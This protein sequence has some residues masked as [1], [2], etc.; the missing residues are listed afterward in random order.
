MPFPVR[1]GPSG[2]ATELPD[3]IDAAPGEVIGQPLTG[4]EGPAEPIPG[5]AVG[6][7]IRFQLVQ[8]TVLDPGSYVVEVDWRA[9]ALVIGTTQ[10]GD[11]NIQGIQLMQTLSA[12]GVPGVPA[13]NSGGKLRIQKEGPLGRVL[14]LHESGGAAEP[15][16][17]I[18]TPGFT[19]WV[20]LSGFDGTWA[21][22]QGS[23]WRLADRRIVP[24]VLGPVAANIGIVFSI[25]VSF[26][27]GGGGAADDVPIYNAAAPFPFRITDVELITVVAVVGATGQLR[28]ASG[29][30]GTTL[31]SA[32]AAATPGT[33]RNNDSATRTVALNG[34]IFLRRSD[35]G[36]AG[37]VVITAVPT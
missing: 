26:A 16:A 4:E 23:R 24:G 21:L 19:S 33:T 9:S 37:E 10:A 25:R 7:L 12:P 3:T 28:S 5:T 31:S 13:S 15:T 1:K 8:I 29:G 6:E 11:V 35:S 18:W 20:L 22:N 2:P 32:M 27:A 14:L 34:S 17:R 30:G 36:F